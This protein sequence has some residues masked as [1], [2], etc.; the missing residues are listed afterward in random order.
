MKAIADLRHNKMK[1]LDLRCA[2]VS[3]FCAELLAVGLE[4]NSAPHKLGLGGNNISD[5]GAEA[6]A[7]ALN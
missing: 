6:L 1:R 2:E 7:K 3:D 5:E 4:V